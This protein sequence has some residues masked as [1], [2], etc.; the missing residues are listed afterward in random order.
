M[1]LNLTIFIFRFMGSAF[2]ARPTAF[3]FMGSAFGARL[4]A[5]GFMGSAFGTRPTSFGFTGSAFGL[6]RSSYLFLIRTAGTAG[7]TGTGI[8]THGNMSFGTIGTSLASTST[9]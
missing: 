9:S 2:G 1:K 4:T 3:G 6:G 7:T 5:F 8:A